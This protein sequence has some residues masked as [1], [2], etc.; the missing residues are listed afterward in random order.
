MLSVVGINHSAPI[1]RYI[2]RNINEV[3]GPARLQKQSRL[4]VNTLAKPTL[5]Y[6]SENLTLNGKDKSRITAAKKQILL[7]TAK[8][9]LF[10]HQINQYILKDDQFWE[11]SK[12]C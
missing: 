11:K 3:L 9:K 5:I 2:M 10:D 8:Y 1:F 7:K 6:G 12:E 4:G